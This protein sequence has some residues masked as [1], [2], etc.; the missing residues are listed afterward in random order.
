MRNGGTYELCMRECVRAGV[1]AMREHA[2]TRTHIWMLSDGCDHP[3][4]DCQVVS[5]VTRVFVGSL[6]VKFVNFTD[7][8]SIKLYFQKK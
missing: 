4:V 7:S 3:S 8:R 2:H 1:R 5:S 6:T